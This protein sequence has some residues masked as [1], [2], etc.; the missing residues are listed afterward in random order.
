[1][2][3]LDGEN[4]HLNSGFKNKTISAGVVQ[5]YQSHINQFI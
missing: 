1:M 2:C 5:R 4:S 3:S